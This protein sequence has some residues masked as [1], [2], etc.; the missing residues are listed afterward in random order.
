MKV[1]NVIFQQQM[2]RLQNEMKEKASVLT[3]NHSNP[4]TSRHQ[5]NQK[6][7]TSKYNSHYKVRNAVQHYEEMIQAVTWY[8]YV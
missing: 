5:E 1:N 4:A 8:L 3:E 7:K 2:Q 6:G